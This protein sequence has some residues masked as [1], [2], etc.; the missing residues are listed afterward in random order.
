MRSC[1]GRDNT[2]FGA[3]KGFLCRRNHL[4]NHL[5]FLLNKFGKIGGVE[6]TLD[7]QLFAAGII[8][9]NPDQVGT[10]DLNPAL[11]QNIFLVGDVAGVFDVIRI[12]FRH[13]YRS[14]RTLDLVNGPSAGLLVKD[15]HGAVIA[16]PGER[17][18]GD[19]LHT[20]GHAVLSTSA[21]LG[22]V[23]AAV[24]GMSGHFF[25]GT[26]IAH[27]QVADDIAFIETGFQ[28]LVFCGDVRIINPQ[29]QCLGTLPE[30]GVT[31]F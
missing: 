23:K 8:L 25:E 3:C 10:G 9:V 20:A 1:K 4:R 17:G 14:G 7:V 27:G 30:E 16:V 18:L 5:V 15:I 22:E 29:P 6:Q 12:V 21:H 11:F 26:K 2:G 28:C 24:G 13:I 19:I 31:G